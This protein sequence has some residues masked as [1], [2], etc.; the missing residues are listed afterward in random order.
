MGISIILVMK[1]GSIDFC[2]EVIVNFHE[3][4]RDG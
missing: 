1:V 4:L 2:M 3:G